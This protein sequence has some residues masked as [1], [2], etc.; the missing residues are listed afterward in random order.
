MSRE[1]KFNVRL[2]VDG[3]EQLQTATM[4]VKVLRNAI[5]DSKKIA[6]QFTK[7]F[8]HFN[9]GIEVVRNLSDAFSYLSDNLRQ[10]AQHTR[11]LVAFTGKSGDEM[12]HLRNGIETVADYFGKDFQEVL[13]ATNA[14]S[15]GFGIEMD[16][17]LKLVRGGLASGADAGGDFLDTLREYPRYFKEAGLSAEDFIAITA[18]AAKQG[19]F[20]D[21]GV[22]VIKE[23]NLRIREMTKATADALEGIGISAD[24]V[25]QQL[26]EGSI[27][28]FEVMQ[29]VAEKLKELPANSSQVGAAIAD[30]FGGPGEDAG[31]EY[32]KTLANVKL[33]MDEVK[34][35]TNG[36]AKQQEDQ[37]KLLEEIKNKL[38]DLIDLSGVYT[39]IAPFLD[40][41]AK[42]GNTLVTIVATVGAFKALNTTQLMVITRTKLLNAAT[43]IWNTTSVSMNALTQTMSATLR[44]AAVSAT[45]LKHAMQGLFIA[46]GVGVAI[47]AL[48]EILSQ[49]SLSL[50][51]AAKLGCHLSEKGVNFIINRDEASPIG[52]LDSQR[53]SRKSIFGKGLLLSTAKAKEEAKKEV[54]ATVWTLSPRELEII[55]AI[56]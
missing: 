8:I 7:D 35:A 55:R 47:V 33:S 5:E 21:K 50:K 10:T 13:R 43:V 1:I 46:S 23:G 16:E 2:N 39:S 12:R 42:F 11:E 28:T 24:L 31:L 51:N 45:T 38:S 29:Q 27:T 54:K 15:K 6:Q 4:D 26:R 49:L 22:D 25:Q 3:K 30:I 37:I 48:T 40:I 36:A 32:I 18:N 52:T 20:S 44:G 34:A 53:A 41:T 19:V 9:Q 17:A 56:D 14:L